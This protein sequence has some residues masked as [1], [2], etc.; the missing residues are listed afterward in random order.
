MVDAGSLL[1]TALQGGEDLSLA[2]PV[3]QGGTLVGIARHPERRA[4]ME[5]VERVD[6]T[7]DGGLAG[8]NRGDIRPGG[9]GKRNVTR[10]GGWTKSRKACRRRSGPIGAAESARV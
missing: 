6:V 5:V 3:R 4:P 1:P 7:V 9:T 10:V 2:D 8:D